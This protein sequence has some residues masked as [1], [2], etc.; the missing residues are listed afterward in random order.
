MS[1]SDVM[2][3][4]MLSWICVENNHEPTQQLQKH[5]QFPLKKIQIAAL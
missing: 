1:C 2:V 4:V 5:K 3:K